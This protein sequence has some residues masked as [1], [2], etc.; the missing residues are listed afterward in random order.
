MGENFKN[1][2]STRYILNKCAPLIA[3]FLFIPPFA[4]AE[5]LNTRFAYVGDIENTAY[6][7]VVQGLDEA[8]HQGEFLGLKYSIDVIPKANTKLDGYLAILVD[9]D[10]KT[11]LKIAS[12]NP[13]TPVFNLTSK[14]DQLRTSCINNL[15]HTIPSNR[16]LQDAEKQWQTKTPDSKAKAEAWHPDFV[17]FAARDLNK[18]F[19]K[20]HKQKMDSN[21]WAGWAAVKMTSNTVANTKITDS[22]DML[23]YLKTELL[24]DGQK[25]E[26]M[27]IRETGQLSQPLLLI[28]NDKIVAE[29]PVRGVA[30]PPTLDSLGILHCKK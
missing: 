2:L 12:A 5:T 17:K 27:R 19:F 30:K 15:L 4:Y 11:L 21:A 1:S 9:A 18:R 7:G 3:F 22:A 26:D 23:K 14:D 24:F 10:Q 13:D 25:G 28:E 6:M 16:M 29:A 20:S 8:N